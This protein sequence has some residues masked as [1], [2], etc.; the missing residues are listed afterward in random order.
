MV[1]QD[2]LPC[3]E[4]QDQD[5]E[6]IVARAIGPVG[7]WQVEK[8][9]LLGLCSVPFAWHFIQYPMITQ[10][11]RFWCK[12]PTGDPGGG[13]GNHTTSTRCPPVEVPC[14][15][16]EFEEDGGVSLQQDFQLVCQNE[17]LLSVRQIV[18]FLG[19]TLGC[20]TTGKLPSL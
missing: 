6:T 20:L 17:D 14:V 8:S 5:E 12:V 7:R 11:K 18:F 4:S 10:E 13:G 19:M 2:T 16:W 9:I 15:E 1:V 3:P